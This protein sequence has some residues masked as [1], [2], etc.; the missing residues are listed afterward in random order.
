MKKTRKLLALVLA[1]LMA[2]SC[3]AMPAMAH[4]NDEGIMQRGPVYKCTQCH[5]GSVSTYQFRDTVTVYR[6]CRS[7]S[8]MHPH[9][10]TYLCTHE[11]CNNCT[12]DAEVSAPE[13]VGDVCQHPL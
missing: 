1:M 9:A 6:T 13:E 11:A 8:Y 10:V 4:E 12:Y 2:F 5:N 3:M 7:C